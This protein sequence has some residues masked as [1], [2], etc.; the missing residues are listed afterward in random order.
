LE[1]TSAALKS[2]GQTVS[3]SISP[4]TEDKTYTVIVKNVK[5]LDGNAI[6]SNN[7]LDFQGIP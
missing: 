3:L 7:H 6:K 1:V 4:Q 5:D 2:D